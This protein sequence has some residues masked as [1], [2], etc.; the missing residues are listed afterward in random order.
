MPATSAAHDARDDSAAIGRVTASL[1][2]RHTRALSSPDFLGRAPGTRGETLTVAYVER[3]LRRAGL[4]PGNPDGTYTQPFTLFNPRTR[5]AA[6]SLSVAGR[7]MALAY[8]TEF[9]AGVA[10][11][12]RRAAV[13]NAP[14]VFVGY[15]IVAPE[16]GW[17]DYKDADVRGK[18]V[19]FIDPVPL[20]TRGDTTIPD[21]ARFG[22]SYWS[23]LE[24][25]R[26][27]AATRGAVGTI[28]IEYDSLRFAAVAR[29][30]GVAGTYALADD[31]VPALAVT[32]ARGPAV[33]LLAGGG[34]DSASAVAAALR[35]DFRPVPL[36]RASFEVA[37]EPRPIPT[38][39]VVAV[40]PGSDPVRRGEYVIVTAHWD[41]WGVG[42][43]PTVSTANDPAGINR[44]AAD[45]A[46]GTAGLLAVARAIGA[47]KPRPPRTIVLIA[48]SAEERGY[49][50]A[51]WYARHPLFPLARTAG[52]VNIDLYGAP[53]GRS[54]DVVIW[55]AGRS[56][57]DALV[58]DIA[59]AQGRRVGPDP[60]RAQGIGMRMDHFPFNEVGIPGVSLAPG[61][62]LIDRP[63]GYAKEK[64]DAWVATRYHAPGD[65]V[66]ADWDFG[67]SRSTCVRRCSWHCGSHERSGGPS[68]TRGQSSPADAT[69]A[70]ERRHGESRPL[71]S[72]D[73][74]RVVVNRTTTSATGPFR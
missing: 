17:D 19:V 41:A 32:L 7:T 43:S 37:S 58:S 34:L 29:R 72:S 8:G 49:N 23:R 57:I 62:D 55:G 60:V 26:Q 38:R 11:A 45:N 42:P 18:F 56:T 51:R 3:E 27:I 28:T 24:V 30:A 67:G 59:R 68:G 69:Y 4:Q 12:Q 73:A 21:F 66:D 50:G 5:G 10:T 35:R 52:M 48:T 40:A 13:Q 46:A 71:P 39:N 47:M 65:T 1:L 63:A 22:R 2:E 20:R 6:G 74:R 25:K 70:L 14:V 33:A 16:L 9:V 61:F 64:L 44:G 54:R 31:P 36:G 53:L 15:G